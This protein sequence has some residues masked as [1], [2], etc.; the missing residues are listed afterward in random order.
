M[1][2][3]ALLAHKKAHDQGMLSCAQE[4][5]HMPVVAEGNVL[6]MDL[7]TVQYSGTTTTWLTARGQKRD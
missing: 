1:E 3:E 6:G 7:N 5:Q 2:P 4:S